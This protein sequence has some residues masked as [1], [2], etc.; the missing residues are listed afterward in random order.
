MTVIQRTLYLVGLVAW[1]TYVNLYPTWVGRSY[2]QDMSDPGVADEIGVFGLRGGEV[3]VEAPLWDPPK[4]SSDAIDAPVRWPGQRVRHSEHVE[5]A[6][7]NI[8]ARLSLG[9]LVLGL[10]LRASTWLITR[11]QPDGLVSLAWYLSLS[12]VVSWI[13]MLAL[14]VI[15]MGSLPTDMGSVGL[16]SVGALA[17]LTYG[18]WTHLRQRS[19]HK[20]IRHGTAQP[21]SRSGQPDEASR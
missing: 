21:S 3:W 5:L 17:G 10:L 4:P 14:A 2:H 20:M 6:L 19:R 11:R 9:V 16:L 13:C 12:L 1:V 18:C 15:T 8:A 7:A